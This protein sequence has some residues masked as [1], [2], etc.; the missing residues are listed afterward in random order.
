MR[1]TCIRR[2]VGAVLVRNGAVISTGYNG[3]CRG[4]VN[5]D[6]GGCERCKSEII[7][8]AGLL[9]CVCMHAEENAVLQAAMLGA[10]TEGAVIFSTLSPCIRCVRVMRNAGIVSCIFAA[11]YTDYNEMAH[12][13]DK[14]GL[15]VS[16]WTYK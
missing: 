8:G 11:L 13:A 15:G 12:I 9:E 7:S 14:I 16:R 5:C 1:S 6:K 3:T 2:K 4:D 10:R